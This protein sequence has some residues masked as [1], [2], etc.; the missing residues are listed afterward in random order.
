[1]KRIFLGMARNIEW[2]P[3]GENTIL[4]FQ[5]EQVDDAGNPIVSPQAMAEKKKT[6]G[7]LV[8]DEER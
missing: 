1:M 8:N 4:T 6:N 7:R 5:L 3:E 2:K